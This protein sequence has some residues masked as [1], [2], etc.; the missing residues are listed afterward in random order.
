[1]CLNGLAKF[2]QQPTTATMSLGQRSTNQSILFA[3]ESDADAI[4]QGSRSAEKELPRK[5]IPRKVQKK[6][7]HYTAT[8]RSLTVVIVRCEATL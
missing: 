7:S 5:S 2:R 3:E 1:M 6:K 8:M 4:T